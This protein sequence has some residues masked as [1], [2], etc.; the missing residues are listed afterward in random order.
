MVVSS[1]IASDMNEWPWR[2]R[3]R[4]AYANFLTQKNCLRKLRK[5]L[6][7]IFRMFISLICNDSYNSCLFYTVRKK[8]PYSEFFWSTFSR[9]RTEYGEIQC[10]SPYSVR[11]WENTDQKDSE[12]GLFSRSVKTRTFVTLTQIWIDIRSI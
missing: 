1:W 6:T 9:I 12:Y 3:I 11:L 4:Q 8:C 5:L 2:W 7:Q 10:T